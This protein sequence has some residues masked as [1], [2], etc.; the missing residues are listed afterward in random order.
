M[1]D[2]ILLDYVNDRLDFH[3]KMDNSK[4]KKLV[5]EKIYMEYSKRLNQ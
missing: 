5:S 3:K 4:I 2:T 1:M